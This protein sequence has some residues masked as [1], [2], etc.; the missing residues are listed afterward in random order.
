MKDTSNKKENKDK[1]NIDKTNNDKTNASWRRKVLD[2]HRNLVIPCLCTRLC[3]SHILPALQGVLTPLAQG[4][5]SGV[6][7]KSDG[8]E[9]DG[10]DDDE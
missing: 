5:W 6:M 7:V 3:A 8:N 9:R 4:W 1:T 2:S 10:M